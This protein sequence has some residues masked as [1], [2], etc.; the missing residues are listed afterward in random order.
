MEDE[1]SRGRV[2]GQEVHKPHIEHLSGFSDRS[3]RGLRVRDSHLD[4]LSKQSEQQMDN[5]AIKQFYE[6]LRCRIC[7][8][9]K[10]LSG[11]KYSPSTICLPLRND[12]FICHMIKSP[13]VKERKLLHFTC[14]P[15]SYNQYSG[16]I[17][18]SPAKYSF[19]PESCQTSSHNSHINRFCTSLTRKFSPSFHEKTRLL[20]VSLY[21]ERRPHPW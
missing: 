17:F 15:L 18:C 13:P 3:A 6:L 1:S 16:E 5:Q 7:D 12:I 20:Q 2:Q 21:G 8:R 10:T 4:K 14:T 19:L 9:P 11:M